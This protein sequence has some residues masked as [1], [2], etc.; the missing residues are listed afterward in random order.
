MNP[1]N[2]EL[3]DYIDYNHNYTA[4]IEV[5][6]EKYR[7]KLTYQNGKYSDSQL[8]EYKLPFPAKMDF[9]TSDLEEII[10]KA[11][12]EMNQDYYSI[13]S[14]RK[15]EIYI[16]SLL[17]EQNVM[18]FAT[19]PAGTGKTYTGVALAVKALKDKEVKSNGKRHTRLFK[20]V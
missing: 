15:K 17:N 12:L 18:V 7:I 1:S 6:D 14:R 5:K 11:R 16:Q 8:N 10:Q 3:T 9:E 4:V 19:G 2:T 13:T 20:R